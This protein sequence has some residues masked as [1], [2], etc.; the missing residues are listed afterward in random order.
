MKTTTLCAAVS[1]ALLLGAATLTSAQTGNMP[2]GS[3]AAHPIKNAEV[4][5]SKAYREDKQRIEAEYKQAKAQCKTEKGNAKDVCMAKAKGDEKVAKAELEA[6]RKG[7]PAARRD[8]QVAKAKADYDVAKEKCDDMKGKEKSACREEAKSDARPG[9][10]P[11]QAGGQEPG[12]RRPARP[13]RRHRDQPGAGCRH[14]GGGNAGPG[15]RQSHDRRAPERRRDHGQRQRGREVSANAGAARAAPAAFPVKTVRI[16]ASAFG[17][18]LLGAAA[19]AVS[20]ALDSPPTLMARPDYEQALGRI[21]AA[22]RASLQRCRGGSAQARLGCATEA[23][24]VDRARRAQLDARYYG[25]VEAKTRARLAQARAE[26][27]IA[28][29]RCGDVP[30]AERAACV[31]AARSDTARAVAGESALAAT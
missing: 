13:P 27:E 4:A 10:R 21:E 30:A 26:F 2:A 12:G 3:S 17:A 6:K 5:S 23:R 25:T 16:A 18:F 1:A 29:A 20:A 11:G 7:T 14:A 28:R 22:T 15:A 9:A 24:A 8:V 31:H 19:Y